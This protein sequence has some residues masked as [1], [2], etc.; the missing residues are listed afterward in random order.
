MATESRPLRFATKLVGPAILVYL[1][2]RLDLA[3][4]GELLAN[5]R[6][7]LFFA[8]VAVFLPTLVLRTV[9]WML[10]ARSTSVRELGF[11]ESFSVYAF[12]ILIG[13][14]TPGRVGEFIKVVHL[15]KRGGSFGSAFF[16]TF[17]DRVLDVAFLVLVGASA[18]SAFVAPGRTTVW[19]VAGVVLAFV[20]LRVFTRGAGARLVTSVIEK[21]VPRPL[22]TRTSETFDSFKGGFDQLTV[23]RLGLY[24]GLT[25]LAWSANYYAVYL[26][27]Q[28]LALEIGYFEMASIA[29]VCSLVTLLPVTVLGVGTRDASLV[30]ML[31]SH[32]ISEPSAIALST[33][34]LALLVG[35]AA[36]CSFSLLTPAAQLEWRRPGAAK[37]G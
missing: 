25:L 20:L 14:V 31:A 5:A 7:P 2:T 13:T 1:L 26:L 3:A 11:A 16:A 10:L 9:R 19:L 27:G 29:A 15:R 36:L 34:I 24:F 21:A 18:L 35:N 22:R 8:A 28:A 37:S 30:A 23:A 12:A 17:V 32:G 6:W 33:L 4:T